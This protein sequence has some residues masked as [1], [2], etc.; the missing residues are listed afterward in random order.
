MSSI[1]M[2]LKINFK[3]NIILISFLLL[4]VA[5]SF[6]TNIKSHLENADSLFIGSPFQL[7]VDINS[8]IADSLYIPPVD[9][10][11]IFILATEPTIN[12]IDLD[13]NTRKTTIS[14]TFQ[15]FDVG[16]FTL[17]PID[18]IVRSNGEL[19]SLKSDE[20]K[21]KI[22]ST[23]PD[24]I[25][26]IADIA[27]VKY[28]H[29]GFWDYLVILIAILIVVTAIFALIKFIKK[30]KEK[31]VETKVVDTRP[32]Y[33]I[34]LKQ[35]ELLKKDDFLR[36]GDFLSYYFRL[37]YIM[38]LFVE[39]QFK[40]KALEMTTAEI[41]LHLT[42]IEPKEK[43]FILNY[44]INCDKIK[45]AKFMPKLSEADFALEEL[46]NYIKSYKTK[47]EQDA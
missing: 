15:P 31:V 9:T 46:E 2:K 23:V 7:V 5:N 27:P 44:L 24:S 30:P 20:Y 22:Y 40:V 10:L 35:I 26:V 14:F 47:E 36:K 25:Q 42:K 34:C 18:F 6:A 38:R 21:L 33:E 11:D 8:T 19:N 43:S 41:R 13:D 17:P 1:I 3:K 37:S 16:E 39:L 4:V 45:F 28:V 12:E 32:A 29:L